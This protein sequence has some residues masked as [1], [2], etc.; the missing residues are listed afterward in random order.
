LRFVG[1]SQLPPM[2]STQHGRS[3][4]LV[5]DLAY[6]V[7][8][9]A[10]LSIRVDAMDWAEAQAQVMSGQADALLQ[11]N[12]NPERAKLYAFS[13]PLLESS[14]HLFRKHTRTD[15]QDLPSLYG[16]RVGVEAA[17]F[18]IQ[19]LQAHNPIKT[20]VIPDWKTGFDMLRTDQLD[21]VFVDRWVGEY[22]LSANRIG[23]VTVVEPPIVSDFSRIAVKKRNAELLAS[24]NSGIKAIEADGTR[25]RILEKW[26]AKEVVYL[27][28]EAIRRMGLYSVLAFMVLLVLATVVSL[29]HA[30]AMRQVNCSARS[31]TASGPRPPCCRPAARSNNA[32]PSARQ[33]CAQVNSGCEGS[34][35]PAS[36]V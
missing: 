29:L 19:Y 14:F 21:A 26:Q 22:V 7:A 3:V 31:R 30:R 28:R 33:H 20:V 1:N 16:K 18:P 25:Q 32:S 27:T 2:I 11:V 8:Q 9:K 23:G 12:P 17:G 6:A 24:I 15:I 35:S 13:E 4:G 10:G 5:V 36:W 34:T